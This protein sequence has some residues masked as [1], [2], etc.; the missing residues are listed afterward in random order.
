VTPASDVYAV[1]VMLFEMLTGRVPFDADSPVAI[2]MKQVSEA[3]PPPS[4]INPGVPAALD[5]VVLRALAKDPA[6]RYQS[7]AEMVAA[8][9]AAEAN[10]QTAGHTERYDTLAP[11]DDG[12]GSGSRRWWWIA[13]IV[14]LLA[15]A[16]ALWFFVF[17][18]DQVRVP[19]VT[20]E[21]ETTATLRLQGAGFE[22]EADRLPNGQP[23]GTV[24]EQD[25]RGGEQAEKGSTVTLSVS[26]GPAPVKV[27]DV[28]GKSRSKAEKRLKR[29][30]FEVTVEEVFDESVPAGRVIETS[31]AAGTL[32]VPGQ[33]VTLVVSRGTEAVSI[34][35]VVGLDRFAAK[36]TLEDAGFVVDQDSQ[37][38]DA[39]EDEVVRQL[40]PAGETRSA[41]STVTIIYSNGA[42]TVVVDDYV[43][44]KQGY[45]E[46]QLAKQD[47]DAVVRFE[48]VD[49]ESD[50]GI[51]LSQ[52][53]PPGSRLSP[54]DR[55]SLVV[56]EFFPPPTNR[57]G[58]R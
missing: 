34:P 31:P 51:V 16:A 58:G 54:G 56:G 12:S 2:A 11:A 22:V 19:G 44:F 43:G 4:S 7:A 47:L 49:N 3:P 48:T 40:P 21:T 52:S 30:G 15:L 39:P 25:P 14:A 45:A 57:L 24:I 37:N 53:P 38:S 18:S 5:S 6:N 8:L 29:A 26:L 28:T 32:L 46:R 23:E 9:D 20:G 1:G 33:T 42:G 41:G 50:D 35:S 55:V 10:P 17:K 13:G 36:S 27:P